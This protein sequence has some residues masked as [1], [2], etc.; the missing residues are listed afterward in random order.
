MKRWSLLVGVAAVLATGVY[1]TV[2]AAAPIPGAH[3]SRATHTR[4]DY[5]FIGTN[6]GGPGLT[7]LGCPFIPHDDG[8]IEAQTAHLTLRTQ[9]WYGPPID[10]TFTQQVLVRAK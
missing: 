2:A 8:A 3:F 10:D 7:G 5:L 4:T 9:G 1:A 6:V